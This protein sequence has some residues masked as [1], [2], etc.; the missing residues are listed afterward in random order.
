MNGKL[1][2]IQ[3]TKKFDESEIN[4]AK[5]H[6]KLLKAKLGNTNFSNQKQTAQPIVSNSNYRKPFNPNFEDER[7]QD[8]SKSSITNSQPNTRKNNTNSNI[9]YNPKGRINKTED[10]V[11]DRPAF[12]KKGIEYE[13]ANIVLTILK[14]L[15]ILMR[16]N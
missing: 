7:K 4:E 3:N 5:E 10:V 9:A 13:F 6:L 12:N 16:M 8:Y 14:M 11:D 1:T 15:K 2:G